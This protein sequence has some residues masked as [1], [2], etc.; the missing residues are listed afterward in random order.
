MSRDL[1]LHAHPHHQALELDDG[2][3]GALVEE[4]T[5][6]LGSQVAAGDTVG[7]VGDHAPAG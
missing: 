3:F 5:R 4:L 2:A 7:G 1:R 6:E